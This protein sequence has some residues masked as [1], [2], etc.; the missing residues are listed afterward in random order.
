MYTTT[1]NPWQTSGFVPQQQFAAQSFLP[2][3]SIPQ[4]QGYNL[5]MQTG[6][7]VV[8]PWGYSLPVNMY[9]PAANI[10]SGF[11][12]QTAISYGF[13][14][15][16]AWQAVNPMVA[17]QFAQASAQMQPQMLNVGGLT[18]GIRATTGFAEPRVELAETNNDVI[19]TAELPNVDPNNIYLL[20]T[21][22]SIS[23]SA[24]AIAGGLTSS[25][26]RTVALPTHVKS[27]FLDVSYTNGTLECRLPKSDLAT[28]R[29]VKVNPTG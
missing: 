25:V 13:N 15:N 16:L 19:V 1:V 10:Q 4:V 24:L 11:V 2:I 28:R 12:P 18:T 29:R 26:H 8:S 22:D 21:D 17:G 6:A 3:Q 14:P 20:V 23:I 5:P 7:T 27:E 9:S